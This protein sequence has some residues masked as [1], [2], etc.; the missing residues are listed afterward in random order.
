MEMTKCDMIKGIVSSVTVFRE[1]ESCSYG[2]ITNIFLTFMESISRMIKASHP[3]PLPLAL[4]DSDSLEKPHNPPT[5]QAVSSTR[6]FA[7]VNMSLFVRL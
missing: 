5:V 4:R 6:M 1:C 2:C 3:H 7:T